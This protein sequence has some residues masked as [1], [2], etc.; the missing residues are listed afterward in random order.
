MSI[1]QT[2]YHTVEN[3]PSLRVFLMEE[4]FEKCYKTAAS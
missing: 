1:Y 4:L 2:G 3:P